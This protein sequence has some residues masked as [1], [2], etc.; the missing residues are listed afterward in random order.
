MYAAAPAGKLTSARP[1]ALLT[2]GNGRCKVPTSPYRSVVLRRGL[3]LLIVTVGTNTGSAAVAEAA[4][5]GKDAGEVG[6]RLDHR[7][8]YS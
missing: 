6:R 5:A 8:R 1:A 3:L 2:L 7:A 4:A